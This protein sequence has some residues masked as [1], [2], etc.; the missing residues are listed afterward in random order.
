VLLTISVTVIAVFVVILT[1]FLI[2]ILLQIRRTS[3]ELEKLAG[4]VR[5]EVVPLSRDMASFFQEA[6]AILQSLRGNVDKL[7]EGLDHVRDIAIRLKGF[8]RD[9]KNRA[10]RPLEKI[11]SLAGAVWVGVDAL[12]RIFRRA[13]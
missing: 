2:P 5:T 11:V 1:V 9:V 8:E 12:L 7:E 13:A 4:A 6:N 10:E 3:T